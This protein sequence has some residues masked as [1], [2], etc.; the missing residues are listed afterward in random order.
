MARRFGA[1]T[2]GSARAFLF[3]TAAACGFLVGSPSG[4]EARADEGL[5]F[6][7]AV[8]GAM[9]KAIAKAE[10]AV[11][12]IARVSIGPNAGDEPADPFQDRR[13]GGGRDRRSAIPT[14]PD[15][16]PSRFGS[17]VVIDK[18]GLILTNYHVIDEDFLRGDGVVKRQVRD[19]VYVWVSPKRVFLAK[20]KAAD[21]RSDL[22]VLEVPATDLTAIEFASEE[23]MKKLKKGQIVISLGNPWAVARDGSASASWGIVSNLHRKAAPQLDRD[24]RE[25]RLLH[26]F[27]S[28]IQTDCRLHQGASGG[29]LI[30][31]EGE[32]V[33]LTNSVAS[34]PG[35]DQGAGFAIPIDD[36]FR[37]V[38]ET[39]KQGKE[40]E[41]GFLG[42]QPE[43][44]TER[45]RLQGFR[46]VRVVDVRG[47]PASS[48]GL[49]RDD[50]VVDINGHRVTD[51]DDLM[52]QIGREPTGA[53]VKIKVLRDGREEQLRTVRLGKYPVAGAK[54]VTELPPA[55]RGLRVDYPPPAN[56]PFGANAQE[57]FAIGEGAVAAVEVQPDTP[58]HAAGLRTGMLITHVSGKRIRSPSDFG[59]AV[60]G[61]KETIDLR[62][63][64]HEDELQVR[65]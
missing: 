18:R 36:T 39:L 62:V 35:Y 65:P 8:Q 14:D 20:V 34:L 59:A 38:V 58:A 22:A 56:G 24:G 44:L 28:L 19:L 42:V 63:V 15:F 64:G 53:M 61:S 52:F 45:E 47:V 41:Y 4:S 21:P 6:A 1:A 9:E 26:Q 29:A 31:L 5:Q 7:L 11:V 32:L 49:R 40:V 43:N 16:V 27:G 30:N 33:G 2:Y 60:A 37:R 50:V 46:G 48:A 25:A 13:P 55:W 54:I 10:G 17:G 51:Q 3:A 12:S 57:L 23:K